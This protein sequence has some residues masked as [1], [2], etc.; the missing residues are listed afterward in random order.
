MRKRYEELDTND[1]LTGKGASSDTPLPDKSEVQSGENYFLPVERVTTDNST[2]PK[3]VAVD[4]PYVVDLANQ[5]VVW[6]TVLRD[7][8]DTE[9]NDEATGIFDRMIQQDK[10]SAATLLVMRD[11]IMQAFGV[12]ETQANNQ[13]RTRFRD[14]YKSL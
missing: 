14:Y 7:M 2:G 5:R 13:L 1:Q 6:E 10:A 12:T 8:D 4:Q 9:Q 11:L 3:R